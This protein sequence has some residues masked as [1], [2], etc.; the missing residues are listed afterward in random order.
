MISEDNSIIHSTLEEGYNFFI[1]DNWKKKYHFKLS[2]FPVPSGLLSEAI[3]VIDRNKE[4]EPRIFHILSDFEADIEKSEMLLKAKIK[5]GINRRHLKNENGKLEIS[6]EQQLRGRIEW[7]DNL[8]DTK[9][10]NIFVIDGKRITMEKFVE[11]V[12]CY[13][14]WNFKFTIYDSTDKLD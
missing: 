2:T 9:F 5:N 14:S 4:N 6:D 1:T 13:A 11:M 7:N 3:Q 12:E 10:N 8:S